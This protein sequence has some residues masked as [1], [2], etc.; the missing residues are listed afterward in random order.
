M[1]PQNGI[2]EKPG[3]LHLLIYWYNK[4]PKLKRCSLRGMIRL[5]SVSKS[6][7]TGERTLTGSDSP[8][9]IFSF[10]NSCLTKALTPSGSQTKRLEVKACFQTSSL[11]VRT[12]ARASAMG[13]STPSGSQKRGQRP[14]FLFFG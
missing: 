5:K 1:K 12:M 13:Y 6:N 8:E 4:L 11:F 2:V 3:L 10:A 9:L 14:L 7:I